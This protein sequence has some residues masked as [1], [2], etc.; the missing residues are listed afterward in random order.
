VA[1]DVT[2]Y[3]VDGRP[4]RGSVPIGKP[5]AN[6]QIYLLD[7]HLQPVPVGVPRE[8]YAGGDDLA[9]GYLARPDPTAERFIPD[10]FAAGSVTNARLCRTGDTGRRDVD[11]NLEYLGRTDHQVK[12]Q[13][14]RIEL[15][16]VE[17]FLARQPG[18]VQCLVVREDPP[19]DRR[20]VA[21]VVLQTGPGDA[22]QLAVTLAAAALR[23]R[24]PQ[25]MVPAAWVTLP[26]M[27]RLCRT[28]L[29][30]STTAASASSRPSTRQLA[31]RSAARSTQNAAGANWRW[32]AL[33]CGWEPART[34]TSTCPPYVTSLAQQLQ[35]CLSAL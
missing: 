13:G 24:L 22:G 20:L 1:G 34:I 4:L 32:A 35:E 7:A 33:R 10:P 21:Y 6:T 28:T 31:G 17:A 11:G 27:P 16:E 23:E 30:E 26:S 19:G 25:Y 2:C 29:R 15:G 14:N 5:I 12:L 9:R 3:V 8:I 18:V